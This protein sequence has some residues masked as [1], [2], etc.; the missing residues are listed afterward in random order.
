MLGDWALLSQISDIRNLFTAGWEPRPLDELEEPE[1]VKFATHQ[2]R[3]NLN[4]NSTEYE[5]FQATFGVEETFRQKWSENLENRSDR[6]ARSRPCERVEAWIMYGLIIGQLLSAGQQGSSCGNQFRDALAALKRSIVEDRYDAL[7]AGLD[8]PSAAVEQIKDESSQCWWGLINSGLLLVIDETI[9]SCKN[10]KARKLGQL[11]YVQGKPHPLGL[12]FNGALQRLL[13]SRQ[14][15][16]VDAQLKWSLLSFSM[17]DALEHL[18]MRSEANQ[19]RAFIVLNDAGFPSQPLLLDP[20]AYQSKFILSVSTS[21]VSGD[22]R[23]L[24]INLQPHAK[25]SQN[26]LF[27]NS[28]LHVWANLRK[29][30][31]YT[32]CIV[33]SAFENLPPPTFPTPMSENEVTGLFEKWKLPR[34]QQ[35]FK[36]AELATGNS[37]HTDICLHVYLKNLTGVDLANPVDETGRVTEKSLQG[38][39]ARRLKLICATLGIKTDDRLTVKEMAESIL[40]NH[41]NSIQFVEHPPVFREIDI[42]ASVSATDVSNAKLRLDDVVKRMLIPQAKP[43]FFADMY[44]QNFGLEDRF[45]QQLYDFF[46]LRKVRQA[47]SKLSVG[48]ILFSL[49]NAYGLWKEHHLAALPDHTARTESQIAKTSLLHFTEMVVIA[50]AEEYADNVPD[51]DENLT[52]PPK[53]WKTK[54]I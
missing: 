3:G 41:P 12:F 13:L 5:V 36:H 49:L 42:P 24:P 29:E 40:K 53:R 15:F 28:R 30:K 9:L 34:L 17:H 22:M 39:N 32:H 2:T 27:Y 21:L 8:L 46:A 6:H 1:M 18:V 47:N 33:T 37:E 31:N 20:H 52:P 38:L 51:P 50:I 16:L 10:R 54:E 4:G 35:F 11:K 19:G 45:D 26:Y 43:A 14:P 23:H 48:F 25:L 7:M 44:S